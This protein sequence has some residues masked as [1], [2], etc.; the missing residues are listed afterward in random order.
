MRYINMV[1]VS[2]QDIFEEAGHVRQFKAGQMIA[3]QGAVAER[4]FYIQKGQVRAF[5]LNPDGKE[6]T[7]FYIDE[8]NMC[9]TESLVSHPHYIVN[10][11]AVVDVTAY[12]IE[13]PVFLREW[14][15]HG[16][17]VENLLTHFVRR[18]L[19]LSDYLCCM[20]FQKNISRVAYLLHTTY[21]D[22]HSP[23]SFTHDEIAGLTSIS[24][25]TVKRYR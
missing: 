10:I 22:S 15:N 14:A 6:I 18:I 3:E 5:L 12:S 16:Y 17:S 19:L 4:L 13:P 20:R 8:G 1:E 7:L 23:I 2:G 21:T 25:I 24:S 9:C 11:A